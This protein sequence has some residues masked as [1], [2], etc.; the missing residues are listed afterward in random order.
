[1]KFWNDWQL[2]FNYTINKDK[3]YKLHSLVLKYRI[4][5]QWF[6]DATTDACDTFTVK[7]DEELDEFSAS[8][9]SSFKCDAQTLI[10]LG[11]RVQMNFTH[12]HAEPFFDSSKF[13]SNNGSFDT[14][15]QRDRNKT[16]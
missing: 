6:P 12:Y 9:G 1:M 2:S 11:P 14:G 5:K 16:L 10:N 7:S 3:K 13:I 15:K 4:D 8:K